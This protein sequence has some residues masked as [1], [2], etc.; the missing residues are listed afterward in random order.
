MNVETAKAKTIVFVEDNPVVLMAYR[1]RLEREGFHVEPAKDGLEAM[2]LLSKIVPDVVILD[3]MLPKFNGPEVLKFIHSTPRLN[4]VCV[5]ILSTNS[6]LE[7][8]DEYLLE[9]ANKRLLKSSCTPAIM[10]R[11]IQES[12]A[13]PTAKDGSKS[14]ES[15]TVDILAG[16]NVAA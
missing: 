5:I 13:N 1:N 12:L 14:S 11:A 6:I 3:L 8:S 16:V 4:T 15:K 10:L 2:K 9:R 7:A